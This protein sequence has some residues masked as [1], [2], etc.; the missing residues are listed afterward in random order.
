MGRERE[1]NIVLKAH[2]L[3][4]HSVIP[5]ITVMIF[6]AYLEFFHTC[7]VAVSSSRGTLTT[8]GIT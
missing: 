7:F 2:S 4:C 8:L 6:G 3:S 5:F 1:N